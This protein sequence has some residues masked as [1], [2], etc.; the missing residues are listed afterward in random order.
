MGYSINLEPLTEC[1]EEM[2]P[3]LT[4]HWKEVALFQDKID[5][6]PDYQRYLNLDK[7]GILFA[8]ILRKDGV[9]V[10]YNLMTFV[11]HPHYKEDLFAIN[12]IVFIEPDHRHGEATV[13]LFNHVEADMR[14]RGASV[15]TYHMK[16][17]KPFEFLMQ[18]LGYQHLEHLYGKCLKG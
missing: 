12:D 8:Y 10:G 14:V 13:R 17:Y 16:V 3:M 6:I 4:K 11:P 9:M 2:K 18:S 7:A 15:I 5:L 1:L